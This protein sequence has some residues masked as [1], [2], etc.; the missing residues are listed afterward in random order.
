MPERE[1]A[2][3]AALKALFAADAEP[4]DDGFSAGVMRRINAR[5]Q[6]RRVV[7]ALAVGAGAVIAA[8]PVGQL[9]LQLSDGLR[10][11]LANTAATDWLMQYRAVLGGAALAF[12]TPVVAALLED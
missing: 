10:A 7:I 6:R 5:I 1:H 8:W 11:L 9:L 4:A 12:M 3:D 2:Q